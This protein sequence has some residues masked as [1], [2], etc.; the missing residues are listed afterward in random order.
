MNQIW[1]DGVKEYNYRLGGITY[2]EFRMFMKG[3]APERETILSTTR[4]SSRQ[5]NPPSSPV[6]EAVPE[7]SVSP[8]PKHKSFTKFDGIGSLDG[9]HMPA[10]ALPPNEKHRVPTDIPFPLELP[11]CPLK[12]ASRSKSLEGQSNPWGEDE[13]SAK[14]RQPKRSSLYSPTTR[15]IDDLEDV[16]R[17]QT[18]S[19]LFVN[20]A[21]YH[22]NLEMRLA[23]L[24]ASK[25]FD[26]K[27]H[28]IMLQ[29]SLQGGRSSALPGASLVMRR[30]TTYNVPLAP[31][32]ESDE[33]EAVEDASR[34]GGRPRRK[35]E[36]THS[37]MTGMLR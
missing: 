29:Q 37:D 24:E 5:L 25:E 22:K 10:L 27:R 35:R 33:M 18:K 21:I 13:E 4:R 8:Q 17:D 31:K 6:L 1:D 14:T 34:R 15:A 28:A 9:L 26:Q 3:Q 11:P 16:V 23:I 2:E 7:G 30:G 32:S 19:A 12:R 36:K 20:R